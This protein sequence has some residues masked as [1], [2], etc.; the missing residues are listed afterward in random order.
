[1]YSHAANPFAKHLGGNFF[2]IFFS[3]R[4]QVNR[5]HIGSV[6]IDIRE[7]LKAFNISQEPLVA[8][9]SPGLFDDSGVSFGC[10]VELNLELHYLYYVGWNLGVTV[11]WRNSI[12]LAISRDGGRT[13]RK[14][15]E[16]P[17]LDR[18]PH[19]PY[20][21]SYPWVLRE[22]TSPVNGESQASRW[23][24]WYGSNLNWGAQQE[25]MKHVIKRATSEDGIYWQTNI[26][27]ICLNL[28]D[29]E[30]GLSR[31]CVIV[32]NGLY[33]MWYSIRRETYRLGYAESADGV[34]WTRLD[35][36]LADDLDRRQDMQNDLG[37]N[38]LEPS[39]G[40]WDSE[41]VCYAHVF[42][43]EGERYMLYCGNGFGRTGFGIARWS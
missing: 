27:N 11:P 15:Q 20:S 10:L 36:Q 9:G 2:R 13:F 41:G 5:S 19:D 43:H 24:M 8:P 26:N 29:G 4:D 22:E 33:K 31:P 35:E 14:F 7:P 21:L 6:D 25:S 30:F 39:L 32:E 42:H 38:I 28:K 3:C 34:H 1:M 18:N 12:G 17:V 16:A 37:Q 40:G 23:V